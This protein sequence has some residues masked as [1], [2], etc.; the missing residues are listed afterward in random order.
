[1]L[2]FNKTLLARAPTQTNITLR[3]F[4]DV[5]DFSSI[6]D[7]FLSSLSYC[8]LATESSHTCYSATFSIVPHGS[9]LKTCFQVTSQVQNTITM[10]PPIITTPPLLH[11]L[12]TST[13]PTAIS[14][15]T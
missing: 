9:G 11:L 7:L 2:P 10:P 6:N 12:L 13:T 14:L 1:M 5:G 4:L 15:P 3:S 8:I